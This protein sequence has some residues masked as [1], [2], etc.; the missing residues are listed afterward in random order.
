MR[1]YGGV[2]SPPSALQHRPLHRSHRLLAG[3]SPERC[4]RRQPVALVPLYSLQPATVHR[5]CGSRRRRLLRR[6]RIVVLSSGCSPV[7]PGSRHTPPPPRRPLLPPHR[8][9]LRQSLPPCPC[10]GRRRHLHLRHRSGKVVLGIVSPP[11]K[12]L[13]GPSSSS[14]IVLVVDVPSVAR[15][16]VSRRRLRHRHRSGVF[17]VVSS[18]APK[19]T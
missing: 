7:S 10:A 4:P 15:L 1:R 18:P 3:N 5:R 19:V 2:P 6:R 17:H 11:S 13:R 16:V 8:R 14:P 9:L 12:P